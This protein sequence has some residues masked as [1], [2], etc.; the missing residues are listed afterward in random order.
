M[1]FVALAP[2]L[3]GLYLRKASEGD[4]GL[5]AG[6]YGLLDGTDSSYILDDLR[7]QIIVSSPPAWREAPRG[8]DDPSLF[9]FDQPWPPPGDVRWGS[10]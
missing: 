6:R 8:I 2:I 5:L 1:T 10:I 9:D 4:L 3:R 7:S